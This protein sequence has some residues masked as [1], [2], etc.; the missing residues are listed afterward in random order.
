MPKVLISDKMSPLA[1]QIFKERGVQVEVKTGMSNEELINCIK[2]YDGLTVRSLT[3]VNEVV[4]AAGKNLNFSD[5]L[6]AFSHESSI[7][8]CFWMF[9]YAFGCF[10]TVL[11]PSIPWS[12][13]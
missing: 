11:E 4:L 12:Q 13:Y 5:V 9:W 7:L 2:H 6:F 8:Q 3:K 1:S 10:F